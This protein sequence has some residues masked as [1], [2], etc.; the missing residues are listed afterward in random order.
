MTAAGRK[1]DR[2]RSLLDRLAWWTIAAFGI[3]IPLAFS[4]ASIEHFRP[5]KELLFREEAIILLGLGAVAAMRRPLRETWREHREVWL[6]VLP[7]TAWAAVCTVAATSPR[8]SADSLITFAA[9]GI[10]FAATA[11]LVRDRSP[12]AAWV[13]IG[14]AVI[15]AVLFLG[16]T[17]QHHGDVLDARTALLGNR[18]DVGSFLAAPALVALILGMRATGRRRWAHFAAAAVIGAALMVGAV[19]SLAA[20]SAGAAVLAVMRLRR[21]AAAVLLIGAAALVAAAVVIPPMRARAAYA[22]SAVRQGDWDALTSNRLLAFYAAGRMLRDHPLTGVGPGCFRHEFFDYKLAVEQDHHELLRSPTRSSNF[23]EVHNDH[24]QVLAEGGIAGYAILL[25]ALYHVARSRGEARLLA[26]PLVVTF[27]VDA[28]AHFPLELAAPRSAYLFAAALCLGWSAHDGTGAA[29]PPRRTSLLLAGVP[30][31][32]AAALSWVLVVEPFRCSVRA[33]RAQQRMLFATRHD[34][35]SSAPIIA[36]ASLEEIAGCPAWRYDDIDILMIRAADNRVLRRLSEAEGDYRR[37][38]DIAPRPE[39][40][41][42]LGLVLIDE[43]RL[44]EARQVLLKAVLFDFHM[45]EEIGRPD[46][47]DWIERTLSEKYPWVLPEGRSPTLMI[48]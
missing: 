30:A 3:A 28:L 39:L 48:R 21:R 45:L 18:D 15:N 33:A 27:A 12:A 20:A 31:A 22:I 38:I 11:I 24:L 10:I 42:N 25:F 35:L 14:P 36:R 37:A 16:E 1:K 13:I 23:G 44:D 19:T 26:V 8:L 2:S 40:Y 17:V 4:P 43:G 29:A 6:L 32:A 5:P 46:V 41:L 34:N 9:A 47:H 7:A